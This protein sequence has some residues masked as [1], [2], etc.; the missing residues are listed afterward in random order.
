MNRCIQN[1]VIY[2]S[3]LILS[4][5]LSTEPVPENNFYRLVP[6]EQIK[7]YDKTSIPGSLVVE[8]VKAIG[9]LR[10]R[11]LLY[12]T[13]KSP[14]VVQQHHYHYWVDSPTSLIR[15]QMVT[16]FRNANLAN[17]VTTERRSGSGDYHLKV[18]MKKL[19]R[20]LL[21]SGRVAVKVTLAMELS[22]SNQVRPLFTRNYSENRE[23]KDPSVL[24]SVRM[25][26]ESLTAIYSRM[27]QDVVDN[28]VR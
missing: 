23:S 8:R 3:M 24:A 16:Y 20:I 21:S 25:M 1:W 5:C 26:N 27:V 19:E 6:I 22:A 17:H 28:L 2:S 11:A 4:G 12:S 10:E 14:E 18:E 13:D 7:R 15:E 9:I